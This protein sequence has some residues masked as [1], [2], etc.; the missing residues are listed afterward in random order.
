MA[1]NAVDAAHFK[2]VH[3]VVTYPEFEVSYEDQKRFFVQ[4]ANMETPRGI[5]EGLSLIHI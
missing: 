5:V 1:E 2:Y 3:G 4:A